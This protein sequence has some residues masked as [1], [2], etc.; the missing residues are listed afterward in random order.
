MIAVR[1][2]PTGGGLPESASMA[3]YIGGEP[4]SPYSVSLT[5]TGPP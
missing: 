2:T 5:G 1:F 3:V 4:N